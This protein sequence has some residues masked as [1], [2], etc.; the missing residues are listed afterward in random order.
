MSQFKI[1]WVG[2]ADTG[3]LQPVAAGAP[4]TRVLLC[5]LRDPAVLPLLRPAPLPG[6]YVDEARPGASNRAYF[7]TRRAALRSFVGLALGVAGETVHIRYDAPGAPRVLAPRAC[8]VSVSG[9]GAIAALAVSSH[10]VGIDL[11]PVMADVEIVP[12]VLHAEERAALA[13]LRGDAAR[14]HFLR[15]WTA[16][17]AFLKARGSGLNQDPATIRMA[18]A[19][20]SIE[21]FFEGEFSVT[22]LAAQ[23][24]EGQFDGV[25][26]IAACVA[27]PL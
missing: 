4:W 22:P 1:E 25:N 21:T 27:L 14:R 17:E 19:D 3:A 26:I 2:V 7:L 10:P 15:L 12:D 20:E 18:V 13:G 5:D 24:R 9:R 23:W 8:H 6:D 16:K 11:E